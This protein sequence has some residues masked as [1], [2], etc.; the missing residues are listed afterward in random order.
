L[1]YGTGHLLLDALLR[2]LLALEPGIDLP[3]LP[4]QHLSRVS[5]SDQRRRL[6]KAHI[7]WLLA[8]QFYVLVKQRQPNLHFSAAQTFPFLLHWLQGQGLPPRLF[9]SPRLVTTPTQPF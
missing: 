1:A 3:D 4:P 2:H 5:D 6:E 7:F 8:E 9:W